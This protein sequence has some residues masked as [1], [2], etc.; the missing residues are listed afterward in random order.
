MLTQQVEQIIK[1]FPPAEPGMTGVIVSNYHYWGNLII[2]ELVRV[3][4]LPLINIHYQYFGFLLSLLLGLSAIVFGQVAN[5]GKV[6]NRWLV[7]F[8]YF[9]GDLIFIVVSFVRKELN[10]QMSSLEDG[11]KFLINMPRAFS[12]I[13]FFAG[14]SLMIIWLRKKE[15][16]TGLLTAI[17]FGSLI[18]LKVY[19]GLFA[20][21]GFLFLGGYLLIKKQF[22]MI[23]IL[24]L[25]II[26]SFIIYLPVN[27]GAGGF[28]FTGFHLFENFIVQ[29]WM[30]FYRLELARVI[31]MEHS[32]WFRV[33]QYDVM[34]VV[35]F[36]VTVFGTKIIGIVQTKKSLS[37]FPK[38][39]NIFM[40][41]GIVVSAIM[42]LFFQ[43]SSGGSNTFNFLVSIF[44]LGS[45]YT[46]L[47]CFYWIN[48]IPKRFSLILVVFI[49]VLTTFRVANYTFE[50]A[51]LLIKHGGFLIDKNELAALSF[52]KKETEKSAIILI[53]Q[54]YNDMSSDSPY[55]S[56][57]I[58]RP[59]FLLGERILRSHGVDASYR[60]QVLNVVLNSNNEASISALLSKNNI[61]YIFLP[62]NKNL[63]ATRAAYFITPVFRNMKAT[64]LKYSESKAREYLDKKMVN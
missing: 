55:M 16:R 41:G 11:A 60:E 45:V 18:G 10:F 38:E 43:Q 29:P 24:I 39:F 64:I 14:I 5:V 51:R 53:D 2:A 9:G 57:L 4:R 26:I 17:I 62:P 6:F 22:G 21:S 61:S 3:F 34:Y 63:V 13:V 56:F 40:I 49:I 31:Y 48:K 30:M 33:I 47:A 23:P 44:I 20:L 1:T 25:T 35:L 42:G 27:S 19:T 59:I 58:D 54:S 12:I 46:A 52:F 36:I 8:L 37:K 50:N 7:F 32:N 15:L 28:Y